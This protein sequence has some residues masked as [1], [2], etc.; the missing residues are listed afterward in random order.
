MAGIRGFLSDGYR[1]SVNAK[2]NRV[3][4]AHKTSRPQTASDGP[5]RSLTA[6]SSE[7]NDLSDESARFVYYEKCEELD[8]APNDVSEQ[9]FIEQFRAA[10][11]RKS[12]NFSGFS[13]GARGLQALMKC[14]INCSCFPFLDLSMNRISDA[15]AALVA[16]YVTRNPPIIHLDL[17][18]NAINVAGF[19]RLFQALRHN[20]H[21][22]SLDFSAID[23][24]ERNRIGTEGSR[25]LAEFLVK[26]QTI[27]Q[28]NLAMSGISS[29]GC[30]MIGHALTVNESLSWLDLCGNRFKTIGCNN[31][32]RENR[33]LGCLESL[34]LARNELGDGIARNFCQQLR[35]NQTLRVLDLSDNGLGKAFLERLWQTLEEAHYIESLSLANNQFRLG[36]DDLFHSLIEEIRSLKYLNS[37]FNPLKDVTL[38]QIADAML[39]NHSIICLDLTETFMGDRSAHKFAAVVAENK[40]LRELH[41]NSN[42]ITDASSVDIAKALAKNH[43]LTRLGMKRNEM[44]DE[45]AQ[46]MMEALDR[47]STLLDLDV[48]FNDFSYRAHVQLTEAI[49]AHRKCLLADFAGIANRH[50]ETLRQDE[51]RLLEVRHGIQ[52]QSDA[53]VS[54][55]EERGKKEKLLEN[56]AQSREK[57]IQE[58]NARLEQVR[59]EY[60][61]ISEERS[62]QF[63]DF[64]KVK[65]ELEKAQSQVLAEYQIIATKRQHTQ[66]RLV[67]AENKKVEVEVRGRRILDDLK[68]HLMT[69]RTQLKHAVEEAHEAQDALMREEAEQKARDEAMALTQAILNAQAKDRQGRPGKARLLTVN[70]R[71]EANLSLG[72]KRPQ[73][74]ARP[75]TPARAPVVT[76]VFEGDPAK[77]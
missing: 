59:Q 31:F 3:I 54:S 61:A 35:L 11:Q 27:A 62:R 8:I 13:L 14:I 55:V 25:A 74:A 41:L 57:Q 53:I 21:I 37:S 34:Y 22:V 23:G 29:E 36:C 4:V 7:H 65:A 72:R 1:R 30:S 50:I 39:E 45:T 15:G 58:A 77:R 70:E 64:N 68:V 60:A 38:I 71:R 19:L 24:I 6:E 67:R 2:M 56:L 18:S 63:L 75:K 5:A 28:L 52:A 44:K 16:D 40:T 43:S 66:A 17:R 26:T 46:Y 73:M 49:A 32:F 20:D 76:P 9:R 42:G 33:S 48:D 51:R 47:N 10:V 69:I 12:L